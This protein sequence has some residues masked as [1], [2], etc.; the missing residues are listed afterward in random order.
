MVICSD[1]A[2]GQS[3]FCSSLRRS[4]CALASTSRFRIFSSPATASSDTCV[5]SDSLARL[6]SCSISALAAARMRSASVLA[7]VRACS[8]ASLLSF[9]PCATMSEA[10]VLASTII[11]AMRFSAFTRLCRPSSPA[12]KPSAICFC[13]VSIARISG[14]QMNFAVNRMNAKNATACINSVRL[15]FMTGSPVIL[16]A[17]SIPARLLQ[18]RRDEGISEREQHRDAQPDDERSVDQAEEQEHLRR[19][20]RDHFRLARGA[21]EEPRAHDA[22]ANAGAKCAK[23][24]HEADADARVC[25]NLRDQ[26]KL[27]HFAFL[28]ERRLDD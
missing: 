17:E 27:V 11:S 13:R 26:L 1:M 20:R 2:S 21:F 7:S 6:T 8:T 12:A 3:C 28:S 24:D 10:R 15:M 19:Q 5:R 4:A 23:A 18:S 22:H 25:L 16:T 14:G 9:S